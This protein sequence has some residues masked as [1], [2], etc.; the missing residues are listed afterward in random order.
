MTLSHDEA[1]VPQ[2]FSAARFV[3]DTSPYPTLR[4][5]YAVCEDIPEISTAHP[6]GQVDSE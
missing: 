4:A 3:V 2:I 6:A 5:I 1:L